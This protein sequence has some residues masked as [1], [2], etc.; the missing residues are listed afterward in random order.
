M[1]QAVMKEEKKAMHILDETT[2]I[3]DIHALGMKENQETSGDL[4]IEKNVVTTEN[5]RISMGMMIEVVGRIVKHQEDMTEDT[6]EITLLAEKI[7]G[8]TLNEISQEGCPETQE[9]LENQFLYQ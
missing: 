1:K 6:I 9:N 4:A 2:A 5:P 8:Q 3:K 7:V